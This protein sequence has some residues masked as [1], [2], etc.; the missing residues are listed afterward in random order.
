MITLRRPEDRGHA[1]HG[2]LKAHLTFSFES[3]FDPE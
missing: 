2:W 3:Y 1:D